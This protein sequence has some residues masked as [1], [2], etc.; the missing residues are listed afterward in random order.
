MELK[1]TEGDCSEDSQSHRAMDANTR[2]PVL[3][4]LSAPKR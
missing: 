4:L 3:F 1:F 2:V